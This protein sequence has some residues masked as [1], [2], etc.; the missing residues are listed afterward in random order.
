MPIIPPSG[1]NY[2]FDTNRPDCKLYVYEESVDA[3]KSAWSNYAN[4][5]YANGN[6]PTGTLTY[7]YYTTSDGQIV[8]SDKLAIKSNTYDNGQG[9]MVLYDELKLIPDNAFYNCDKLISITIPDCVNMIGRG[10]FKDCSNLLSVNFGNGIT[11][12]SGSAFYNCGNLTSITLPDS[13]REIGSYAFAKCNKLEYAALG[14]GITYMEQHVF[15]GCDRLE[16]FRGELAS[17]DGRCLVIKGILYSFA[18]YGITEYTIPNNVTTIDW[19]AFSLIGSLTAITIP[20]SVTDIGD[21]AFNGCSNLTTVTISDKIEYI[22][23]YA[24]NSCSKLKNVYCKATEPPRLGE[25]VFYSNAYGRKI[26]VPSESVNKYKDSYANNGW[27]DYEYYNAI[28]G[29]NF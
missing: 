6:C 2:A 17:G 4:I 10:A 16:E 7:I 20:E 8:S 14:K 29:Y 22:G 15:N 13:V 19:Y 9:K 11:V 23:G 1:G 12:I 25:A 24:F 18:P 28:T 27:N 21:G 5:I 3:Y 26:Y